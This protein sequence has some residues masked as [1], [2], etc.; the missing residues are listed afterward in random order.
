[1]TTADG[2]LGLVETQRVVLFEEGSPLVLASGRELAPVEV[3]F[4]TYGTLSPERDNVVFLCHALTGDAHAAGHHGDSS[5]R[6]WWDN[7]IGP[8]RPVDTDRYFVVCPNLL[9][10]CQ[11]TTGPASTDPR[12]GKPYGLRFPA[13]TV[14]DL[15]AVHRA[16]L[17]HLGIERPMAVLGGSLGGMQAL[18][19]ALDYPTEVPGAAMVCATSRLTAQNIAFSA[20]AREAIMRDPDFNG[21]DFY[22]QEKGPELGLALARMTAHITYLSE[23]AMRQ[24]FGRR[25][26]D[27]SAPTPDPDAPESD[28]EVDFEVESYLRHQGTAFLDRFDANTYLY[29]SRMMDRFDPFADNQVFERLKTLVTRFLLVSFDTDW[30]FDSSHS[31][32]I[33]RQLARA[34]V[35]VS[36]RE[37]ESPWGHDSFLLEVPE[38]HRTVDTFLDSLWRE[39]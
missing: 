7:I 4:E 37:I 31:R 32:V 38:Y 11:G 12:T 10:G 36:F 3:A 6:G 2:P 21:G 8:G 34:G 16:L 23:E 20:V 24:K 29:F 17:S 26:Q 9:G 30:R 5:E 25:R 35:P 22:D 18:Q 27:P 13:I 14:K 28:F 33:Q 15:V 1:M 19:W 39:R